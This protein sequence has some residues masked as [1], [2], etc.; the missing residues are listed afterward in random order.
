MR[1][2]HHTAVYPVIQLMANQGDPC[3]AEKTSLLSSPADYLDILLVNVE[4]IFLPI[5]LLAAISGL[6]SGHFWYQ[7]HRFSY[8]VCGYFVI[9]V[10]RYAG[11][12]QLRLPSLNQIYIRRSL[13]QLD[14]LAAH[15]LHMKEL[16]VKW[17]A[18]SE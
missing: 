12:L 8:S 17:L 5:L 18:D 16:K 11:F 1:D 13:H 7:F 2:Y 9:G 10:S 14:S 15:S 3:I 6:E 4:L